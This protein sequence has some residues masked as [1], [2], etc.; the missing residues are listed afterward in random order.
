MPSLTRYVRVQQIPSAEVQGETVL[1]S[2]EK[3]SYFG[4]RD[5]ARRIW[6]LLQEPQTLDGLCGRLGAEFD[7]PEERCRAE[8][9]AF[10]T[11][12][13]NECLVQVSQ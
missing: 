11:K 2:L 1:L 9:A 13:E 7:V 3:Q 5:V 12:L 8:V 6:D 10:L 4:L